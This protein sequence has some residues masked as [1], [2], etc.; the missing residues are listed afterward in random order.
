MPSTHEDLD[1]Q[2]L[3]ILLAHQGKPNRIGRWELVE[4]VKGVP[5]P[6]ELR[7]DDNLDDREIRYAV[8]RLRAAGHLICD[9][10][11]GAGRWMAANEKEFWEFYGY[12]VKPIKSKSEVARAMMKAAKQRWPNLMQPRLFD[13][14]EMEPV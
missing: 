2:V 14:A 12:F 4:Q 3:H 13:L 6:M 10:G 9:L 7:N 8:G 5:A 11:D 1:R